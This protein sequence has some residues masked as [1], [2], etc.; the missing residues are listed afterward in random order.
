MRNWDDLRFSLALARHKT[1]AAAAISLDANVATVSRRIAR[2][3]EDFGETLFV[4]SGHAWTTTPSGA[5]LVAFAEAFSDNLREI[6]R[7]ARVEQGTTVRIGCELPLIQTF[8]VNGTAAFLAERPDINIELRLPGSLALGEVDLVI[9][10]TEPVEGSLVRQKVANVACDVYAGEAF[11]NRVEGW[12]YISYGVSIG[13]QDFFA[14][15]LSAKPR[16]RLDGMNLAADAMKCLPLAAVLPDHYAAQHSA[17][18][19]VEHASEIRDIGVWMSFH[20]SRKRDPVIRLAKEF[21][22]SGLASKAIIYPAEEG[23][24]A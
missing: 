16:L 20:A 11:S 18:L 7:P 14:R 23:E 8:F 3:T 4:K 6:D 1:M 22:L 17:L 5:R 24:I 13:Q 2:L 21:V 9:G 12:I 19:R 15:L 10:A